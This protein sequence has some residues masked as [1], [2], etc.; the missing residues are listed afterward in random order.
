M[1]SPSPQNVLLSPARRNAFALRLAEWERKLERSSEKPARKRVHELRVATQRLLAEMEYCR[2]GIPLK[3][4]S[5]KLLRA[6]QKQ[7]RQL[8]RRMG[9]V[10]DLDVALEG[11]TRLERSAQMAGDRSCRVEAVCFRR[12]LCEQRRQAARQLKKA[13]G[14]K[15][16][17][18]RELCGQLGASTSGEMAQLKRIAPREIAGFLQKLVDEFLPLEAEQ[19]HRFRK[20]VRQLRSLLEYLSGESLWARNLAAWLRPM[21]VSVGRWRDLC[22][23]RQLAVQAHAGQLADLIAAREEDALQAALECCRMRLTAFYD[24]SESIIGGI[25]AERERTSV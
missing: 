20:R 3:R 21:Q 17:R 2:A 15:A 22:V 16:E 4:K 14:K 8:R 7:G 12:I 5:A 19:L 10:R 13:I 9:A 25:S 18:R 11:L 1:K 6:W 24:S 23:L